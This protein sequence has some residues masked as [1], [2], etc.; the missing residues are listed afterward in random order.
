MR[1]EIKNMERYKQLHDFS[2]LIFERGITPTD[3]DLVI[4]FGRRQWVLGEIKS[5]GKALPRGQ[6]MA[7]EAALLAHTQAGIDCLGFVADHDT[8]S[9]ELIHVAN[10]PV[11]EY[12]LSQHKHWSPVHGYPG[13]TVKEFIEAWRAWLVRQNFS[14]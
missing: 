8:A 6:R 12:W 1:G 3:F 13:R 10:L 9:H 14:P 5:V 7:I 2:E 11:R 4:D